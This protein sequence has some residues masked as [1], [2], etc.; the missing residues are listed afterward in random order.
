ML[1]KRIAAICF[2]L[3]FLM[4]I[5][6]FTGIGAQNIPRLIA[7]FLFLGFGAL[8]LN[9]IL[10]SLGIN[11]RFK[12]SS[13]KEIN[14]LIQIN[15]LK[16]EAYFKLEKQVLERT[17]EIELKKQEIQEKNTEIISSISYAK[18]IQEAL[19]PSDEKIKH[20]LPAS[21]LWYAPKDIVAGDF[22]WVDQKHFNG[23][24]YTFFAVGDCTGHGVPGAMMS[25]L[26]VNALNASLA[27]TVA[28]GTAK[29]L[30]ICNR[31]L[32][33]NLNQH[34]PDLNDGMD[35]SLCCF[36]PESSTLYWSGANSP[37]WILQNNELIEYTGTRRPIGKSISTQDFEEQKI[38][39]NNTDR[40]FLF[41]DGIVD[42]FGGDYSKKFKK[43]QLRKSILASAGV[44]LNEQLNFIKSNILD[45]KGSTE[46]VDDIALL[47][48]ECG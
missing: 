46:Q 30:E 44:T 20:L 48:V 32:N 9:L 24:N 39:L 6:L 42:Q 26:C 43:V 36:E 25:V 34:S 13:D 2:T 23:K 22:Y 16:D 5:I 45:W 7:E 37:L 17:K 15:A 18:R 8:V 1:F 21:E 12:N 4:A 14:R 40:L 3:A 28:P 35:I 11:F 31:L 29:M 47:I 10:L 19:L 38:T 41:S 33:D 27:K